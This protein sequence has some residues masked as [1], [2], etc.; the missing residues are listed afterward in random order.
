MVQCAS[1]QNLHLE[2][3][4]VSAAFSSVE[5]IFFNHAF[6]PTSKFTTLPAAVS[7]N[8]ASFGTGPVW[9]WLSG[10]EGT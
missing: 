7:V 4:G 2:S 9:W 3:Q 10:L 6:P 8:G 5:N 1:A